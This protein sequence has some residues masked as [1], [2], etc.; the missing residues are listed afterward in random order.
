MTL[1]PLGEVLQEI[2][3]DIEDPARDFER[4]G[5]TDHSSIRAFGQMYAAHVTAGILEEC[6]EITYQDIGATVV[7]GIYIGMEYVRRTME[8][9]GRPPWELGA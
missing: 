7:G 6:G 1:G 2:T 5:V 4:L 9:E 3:F 8:Q